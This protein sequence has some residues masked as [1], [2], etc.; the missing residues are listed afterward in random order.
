MKIRDYMIISVL[1]LFLAACQTDKIPVPE[2]NTD[3]TEQ[4]DDTDQPEDEPEDK[5]VNEELLL[6]L[7]ATL[8][9]MVESRKRVINAWQ[10]GN[11]IGLYTENKNLKYTYDGSKWIAAEQYEVQKEQT[12]YAYHP[13]TEN[14]DMPYVPV[15]LTR[16]EDVMYGQCIVTPDFPT[17]KPEMK[18]ALSLIRVKLLRDEYMG[19][20]LVTDV[21]VRNVNSHLAMDVVYGNIAY[22][23]AQKCDIPI[24]GG[25]MLNDA[26]PTVSEAILPPLYHPDGV[27]LS[28]K[29][30]GKEMNYTFPSWHDW[31]AGNIYTYTIKIKGAYNAEINKEDVPIDVEYWSQFG[32]TDEI[33]LKNVD[34]TDFENMFFISTN[35][36][37]FGYDCYQNEGKPFGLFYTH[38]GSEPFE[39]KLRFVFMQGGQ[40]VEKFQPID[41]KI[42]GDWDGKKIQCYVTSA[43]GT[44]QLVPLFQRNG[45]STWFKAL[46]YERNGSDAEWMYEVK[47]PAPDNLPALRDILLEKEGDNTNFLA[48]RVPFN[49]SFNVVYTLSNKGKKALKGEIKAVWEREFKLKSNSF[50]PSTQ[51][52]N[53][54]NDVQWADEIGRV[55][56][57]IQPGIRYW[58]GIMECK[59]TKYYKS[60]T[61]SNG[62]GYATPV[63]H[64]YWKPEGSSEW[65]LLRLD[66][67]YLFNNNYQGAD[68]WDET[69]NYI[70]LILSDWN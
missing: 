4:T 41:I 26:N 68:V 45:E 37:E 48:Y 46:G 25:F 38:A 7:D 20:G 40:I 35:Y 61:D 32:K 54:T 1:P 33:V 8:K 43:P 2:K 6:G 5:P 18:H 63:L 64:L 44:Y 49:E 34:Y 29:L 51:K 56:V 55:S 12:V 28:F 27:S 22:P 31:E 30:D 69:L 10:S 62:I 39:G 60:P 47:A 50:R 3:N 53:T 15:D 11:E 16:Q 13:Y 23:D 24:G 19:T 52:L 14:V 17:A 58:K 59:V 57:D 67:D 66:A 70:N 21:T 65:T 42:Q 36:T 9:N